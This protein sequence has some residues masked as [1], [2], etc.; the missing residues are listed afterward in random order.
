MHNET[1]DTTSTR[2]LFELNVCVLRVCLC[3]C[4]LDSFNRSANINKN[5]FEINTLR[6]GAGWL[7]DLPS[8]R[9]TFHVIS[10][11]R[12]ETRMEMFS[13]SNFLCALLARVLGYLEPGDESRCACC[14]CRKFVRCVH[15]ALGLFILIKLSI[16]I[17]AISI[18]VN[19]LSLFVHSFRFQSISIS[20]RP[21]RLV[22][23]VA[24]VRHTAI[25]SR[26]L[27]V[28]AVV[29]RCVVTCGIRSKNSFR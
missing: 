5:S 20:I 22:H 18:S 1:K 4:A 16:F 6:G 13:H 28:F 14:L 21:I 12:N 25:N 8:I 24:P 19:S 27:C 9:F 29:I 11:K 2:C 23:A 17:D 7:A 26:V 15:V 10:T 3:A